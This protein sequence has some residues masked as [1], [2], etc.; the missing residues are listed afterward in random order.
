MTAGT[1]DPA[2]YDALR[3]LMQDERKR[4]VVSF[5]GG[6]VPGICC[7]L[8]LADL[9]EKLDLRRCVSQVWGTSAGAVVGGGWASGSSASKILDEVRALDR[10]GAVDVQ[11]R[12]LALALL[13]RPFGR[14]LPDGIVGGRHFQAAV[15]RGLTAQSFEECPTEFRCIAVTDDGKL[16]RKVFRQ[17]PLLPAILASMSLPGVFLPHPHPD[18]ST[19]YDGGLLEKTP[20]ISPIAEHDRRGDGRELLLIGTHYDNEINKVAAHG[21]VSR[22]VQTLY[23]METVAWDYQLAEARQRKGVTLLLLNPHHDDRSLFDFTRVDANFAQAAA[24]FADR[25]QN[26]KLGFGLGAV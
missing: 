2:R 20:L 18:G 24:V 6:G 5:G 19:Y 22:F 26:A 11:W 15:A 21:F 3:R 8:A 9:L 25:L 1:L 14:A 7:N 12:R 4:V 13:L 17:G 16:A 23:A 10:R